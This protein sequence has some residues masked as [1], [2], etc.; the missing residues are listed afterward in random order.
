[1]SSPDNPNGARFA[2]RLENAFA[3]DRVFRPGTSEYDE[4]TS[5]DNNSFPQHPDV[6]VR[7]QSAADVATVVTMARADGLRVGVQSTGHGAGEAMGGGLV[8]VDTSALQWVTIDAPTRIARVGAGAQW[9][10]TQSEAE[11]HGLLGLSG[12]SPTVGVAGYTVN[13]GVGWLVRPHGL[14]SATLR[15]VEY[16]DGLGAVRRTDAPDADPDALWAFRGGAPVG[17]ATELELDLVA[18]ADLWAG[19]LLWPAE[20]LPALAAA[21]VEQ[22]ADVAAG[23][24]STLALLQVPPEGPFPKELLGT[25]VVHLSYASVDGEAGLAALRE[26]MSAVA[27]PAADTTGPADSTGLATIHLDPPAAVPARGSGR[28]LERVDAGQLV[29]IFQAAGVG[30]DDDDDGLNM[31]ELRHVASSGP[32][33]PIADG[34][35][36]VVP[37]PFLLHAVGGAPD[38]DGRR[39]VDA[40]L[41]RVDAAAADVSI[42]RSAP[43]FCEGQ[44]HTGEAYPAAVL[45]R[46]LAAVRRQDPDGIF[47]FQRVAGPESVQLTGR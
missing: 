31:I 47:A 9:A 43:G 12:T 41:A 6:V 4:A 21:W 23:M 2:D 1:V 38:D 26:A 34:A 20:H 28:W 25:V 8:L 17:I 33:R 30:G 5:P 32:A 44:P 3:P 45:D 39:A 7:P 18:V 24:T 46:L 37:A 27:A 16:V 14:A 22:L 10:Q 11:K 13:G 36:S 40:R 15:A 35:L 42:G 29:T 19:Y